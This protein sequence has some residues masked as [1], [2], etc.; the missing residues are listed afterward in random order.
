MLGVLGDEWTLLIIQ[1]SLLGARRYGE[2]AAALPVSN[3]VLSGRLQSMTADDLLV[4]R[5]YQLNPPR[6]EY[7]P[8]A[9]S[10]AL[11]P[12]LTS[13][14]AWE[15]AWVRDRSDPLPVM[16]HVVCGADFAPRV[17][18]GACGVTTQ[19]G[20]IV[21]RWG[22]SGSWQ[23]SIPVSATRRRSAGRRSATTL[24]FPQT[25]SVIG[26]R[27][28]FAM[29]VAA[30]VGV[31][32]FTDFQNALGAPPGTAAARLSTFTA[33]GILERGDDGYRLTDKGRAFFGVLVCALAWAQ[34]WF[35]DPGGPAV[36][37]THRAC[38]RR[39]SPA[40]ECNRCGGRLRGA[41]IRALASRL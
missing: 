30:F 37:L 40:L 31:A 20:D 8:T 5:E 2:F 29:L 39:F 12:M 18:C 17:A 14:W 3:A 25:M 27:W 16:R 9:R 23:R 13:I 24:L 19:S 41:D 26:D 28:A 10:R 36:I 32:R 22:P 1:Q 11:W 34:H 38:G 21:A 4:R 6:A 33:E 35:A 7:L 15:R